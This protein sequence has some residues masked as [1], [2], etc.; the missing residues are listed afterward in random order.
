[1]VRFLEVKGGGGSSTSPDA[2]IVDDSEAGLVCPGKF[3]L[4]AP[5]PPDPGADETNGWVVVA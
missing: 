3:G 2:A 1:M 4:G 5:C